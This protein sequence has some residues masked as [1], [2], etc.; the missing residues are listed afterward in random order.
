MSVIYLYP[1]SKIA[2]VEVKFLRD[3]PPHTEFVPMIEG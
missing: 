2:Q 1:V 3:A